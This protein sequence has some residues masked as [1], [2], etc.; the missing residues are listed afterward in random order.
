MIKYL[1]QLFTHKPRFKKGDI[2][3]CVNSPE[4]LEI[5]KVENNCYEYKY[6]RLGVICR[7][8]CEQI[9][10]EYLLVATKC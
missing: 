10:G 4:F 2:I 8:D 6:Q 7:Y 5:L 1:K 3:G 9:D